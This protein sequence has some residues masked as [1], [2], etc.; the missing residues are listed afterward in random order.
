MKVLY[1][2]PELDAHQEEASVHVSVLP[3]RLNLDQ[4]TV[5]FLYNYIQQAGDSTHCEGF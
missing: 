4:D 1:T 2:R 3:I 5:L